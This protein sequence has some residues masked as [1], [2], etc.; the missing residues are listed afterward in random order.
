M[1]ADKDR[2]WR[3]W[4]EEEWRKE[5]TEWLYMWMWVPDRMVSLVERNLV[6]QG[7]KFSVNERQ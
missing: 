2:R 7:P 5:D 3:C 6:S 4:N 1:G